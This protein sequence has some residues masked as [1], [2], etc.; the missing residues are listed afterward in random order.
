MKKYNARQYTKCIKISKIAKTKTANKPTS[1]PI[2]ERKATVQSKEKEQKNSKKESV[3]S[4]ESSLV[5]QQQHQ[6]HYPK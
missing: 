2:I 5:Q 4:K 1:K 6:H 3:Q